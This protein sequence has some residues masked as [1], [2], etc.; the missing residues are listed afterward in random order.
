[1]ASYGWDDEMDGYMGRYDA[2]REA[3][4]LELDTSYEWTCAQADALELDRAFNK[5]AIGSKAAQR[6]RHIRA[7]AGVTRL[8]PWEKRKAAAVEVEAVEVEGFPW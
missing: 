7:L 1:M 8:T 4:Y 3:H 2:Q 6:R 5:R